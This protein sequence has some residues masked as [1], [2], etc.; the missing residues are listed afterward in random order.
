MIKVERIKQQNSSN[1]AP[2]ST[3]EGLMRKMFPEN[4]TS[5]IN[6]VKFQPMTN[7]SIFFPRLEGI[8]LEAGYFNKLRRRIMITK[9]DQFDDVK[10]K[11][12]YEEL[13]PHAVKED[14]AK[15]ASDDYR[16]RVVKAHQSIEKQVIKTDDW[17]AEGLREDTPDT[18]MI[19]GT[20]TWCQLKDLV[21]LLDQDILGNV[22]FKVALDK[23]VQAYRI[24]YP[25]K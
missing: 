8:S 13:R 10:L 23:A 22:E 25:G 2:R 1:E 5:I 15:Q 6:G 9:D 21:G 19:W 20:A 7:H 18:V 24:L 17:R 4:T 14:E 3:F 12:K 16:T 11:E